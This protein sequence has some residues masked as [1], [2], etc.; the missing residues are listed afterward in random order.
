MNQTEE[1]GEGPT[2]PFSTGP[3]YNRAQGRF[4]LSIN[5]LPDLHAPSLVVINI[6]NTEFAKMLSRVKYQQQEDARCAISDLYQSVFSAYDTSALQGGGGII[7]SKVAKLNHDVSRCDG[8]IVAAQRFFIS[9][10]SC[11]HL[12]VMV[13]FGV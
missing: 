2:N 8:K 5:I 1:W 11:S 4:F 10:S 6:V 13:S 3:V 9:L 12:L 7:D